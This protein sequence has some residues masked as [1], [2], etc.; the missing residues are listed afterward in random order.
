VSSSA[1]RDEIEVKLPAD[2]DAVREKLGTFGALRRALHDEVNDLYDDADGRLSESRRALR[3]RRA[4]GRAILTYKGPPRFEDGNKIREEREIEISDALEAEAILDGLG[5]RRRFRYEKR[6]EEWDAEGCV[7]AL[8]QTPIGDFVEVEGDPAAI[9]RLVA[10]L[11]L[12]S[13]AAIPYSYAELY[14]RRRKEDPSLP[15]N[16]IWTNANPV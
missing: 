11:E 3:L 2:L 4:D 10:R 12:D 16:M 14:R 5:L 8:D 13:S 9:R 6:R 7:V 15:E 1:R